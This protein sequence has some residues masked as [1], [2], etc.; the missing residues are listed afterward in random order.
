V[1]NWT[2]V[3]VERIAEGIDRQM[4]TGERLMICR[5]SFAPGVVTQVHQHPH[6]QMTIVERGRVRFFV[7]GREQLAGAGDV[8]IFP[9]GIAH[10]ATI[11]DEPAVLIDIFSPPREDFLAPRGERA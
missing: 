6:E 4:L 5:L 3:P 11:L 10:G 8:L 2:T 9:S 7:A 1:R